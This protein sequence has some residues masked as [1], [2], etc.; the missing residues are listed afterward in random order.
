VT[1]GR[2]D[3]LDE[4]SVRT[5]SRG[6]SRP[7]TKTRPE[8]EDAV[9]ARVVAVDRGRYRCLPDPDGSGSGASPGAGSVPSSTEHQDTADR[10][11]TA[12]RARELRQQI[13]V[14]DRVGLVGDLSGV[15]GALARVVRVDER[16]TVL[17][18]SADDADPVER[19]IV[20]NVDQMAIVTAVTN[21]EPRVGLIDRCVVAAM[22]AG[23]RPVL[24][25][26]KTDLGDPTTLMSEYRDLGI[27]SIP[28]HIGGDLAPLR[29]LV[30]EH[31]TVFVGHSGVGKSSLV[32]AL[33]PGAR[34]RVGAVNAVTGRGRHTST[35]VVALQLPDGDGWIIDTP[36]IRSFGLAHVTP[37]ALVAGFTDLAR[38]TAT[39][40]RGCSHDEPS[41]AL[42]DWVARGEAT[43]ER[44]HSLRR[45]LRG[46]RESG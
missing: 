17:R 7:R 21:P 10:L 13:V 4:D 9:T 3:H 32:N 43:P 28:W 1:P 18:R 26:T 37:A 46:M 39:C 31:A 23:I 14:G 19:I 42:D 44:L 11:V 5:R 29:R 27:D 38:G 20:A 6:R 16:R 25:V 45:L 41:C 34:R 33:L 24:L 8:H 22:D 30:A 15:P 2:Y 12:M 40:P 35:S 36:G